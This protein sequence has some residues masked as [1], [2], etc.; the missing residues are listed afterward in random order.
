MKSPGRLGLVS[1]VSLNDGRLGVRRFMCVSRRNPNSRSI[2]VLGNLDLG[3]GIRI[4]VGFS[5]IFVVIHLG[6]DDG[7]AVIGNLGN[8]GNRNWLPPGTPAWLE[9]GF[10]YTRG[11]SAGCEAPHFGQTAGDR[12]RS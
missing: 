1:R 12:F 11:F 4:G 9:T 7:I 3:L 2:G 6:F 5:R 8:C 10:E